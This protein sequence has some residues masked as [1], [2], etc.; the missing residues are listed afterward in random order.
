[1]IFIF[2]FASPQPTTQFFNVF[3][4]RYLVFS[5]TNCNASNDRWKMEAQLR[6]QNSFVSLCNQFSTLIP[7]SF[8]LTNKHETTK[9]TRESG[10][11]LLSVDRERQFYVHSALSPSHLSLFLLISWSF[12]A[13]LRHVY[14]RLA[15][16]WPS[17]GD[18]QSMSPS[19]LSLIT[20][21]HSPFF[22]LSC[23]PFLHFFLNFQRNGG[24]IQRSGYW[25]E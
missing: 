12:D 9:T 19:H 10:L 21:K 2:I 13:R 24:S 7:L 18:T 11:K 6:R 25:S 3:K 16:F 23:R 15:I 8:S 22:P 17:F 14:P 5:C 20:N 4:V 1:M